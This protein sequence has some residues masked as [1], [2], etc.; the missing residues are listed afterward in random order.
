MF[1]NIDYK[2]VG[3]ALFGFFA[4]A[5]LSIMIIQFTTIGDVIDAGKFAG[6]IEELNRVYKILLVNF[7]I[8]F[9]MS[10][11]GIGVSGFV[12]FS[13]YKNSATLN[14]LL[15]FNSILFL[16]VTISIIGITANTMA[17]INSEFISGTSKGALALGIISLIIGLASLCISADNYELAT[18]IVGGLGA[19]TSAIGSVLLLS[20]SGKTSEITA[21]LVFLM[22]VGFVATINCA[23]IS[24]QGFYKKKFKAYKPQ[25]SY[26]NPSYNPQPKPEEKVN[27]VEKLKELKDLLD[28]GIISQEE[29][30]EKRKKYL[31]KL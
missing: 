1:D 18:R 11:V 5:F 17:E 24:E 6:Q 27:P 13:I 8:P 25:T 30:E 22:L 19:L 9:V 2:K 28:S 15:K 12:L 21:L 31:D 7:L 29:Y 26:S 3:Y 10:L 20:E 16:A 14:S 4:V 23:L